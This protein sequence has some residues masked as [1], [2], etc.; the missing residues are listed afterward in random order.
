VLPAGR[1]RAGAAR[2]LAPA[3]FLL[4]VTIAVLLIRSGLSGGSSTTSTGA[5]PATHPSARTAPTTTKH[6]SK[7]RRSAQYY[8]VESGDTF[9]SI[10]ARTGVDIAQLERLNPGVSSNALHVGQKIRVK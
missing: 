3:A 8:T 6:R 1:G 4:A 2:Y 9:G 7:S 5:G 10:S